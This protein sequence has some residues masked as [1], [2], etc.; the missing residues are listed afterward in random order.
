MCV[1]VATNLE[2]G[3]QPVVRRLQRL[4]HIG[5][6]GGEVHHFAALPLLP[7]L[8]REAEIVELLHKLWALALRQLKE[9]VGLLCNRDRESG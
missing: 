4:N 7:C 5:H 8:Q 3:K 1:G 6:L 9:L 2:F